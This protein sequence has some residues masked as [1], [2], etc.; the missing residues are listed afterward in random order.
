MYRNN[1]YK[2]R[3]LY[4][5]F[6][7]TLGISSYGQSALLDLKV[8]QLTS[9]GK[10]H[11][12]G[13]IGQ[14][15]T[16][17]WNESGRYILGLEVD[18]IHRMP[19]PEEAAKVFIIDTK[20]DNK[21]IYLDET[22]AWNHQQGTMFYW[23]PKA[24]K[25][26]FFFND[27]DIR[28][29]KVF[30]VLFDIEKKKRIKEYR[31]EDSSV[32][33]G[34]VAWDGSFFMGINYGRLAR[35]RLVTGYPDALDWS[36]E[37]VAP[38]NDGIFKIDIATGKKE[39]LVS[40]RQM[41]NEIIKYDKDFNN[42]GLFINHTLLNRKGDRLY[43]FA[44]E[45]WV[46]GGNKTNVAFSVHLD[47][48][49]LTRHEQHIGGHP[50]WAEG[51]LLIGRQGNKQIFYD[52]DT[53][54]VVKQLG[55][56]EIFPNPEGDIALSPDGNWFVNGYKKGPENF[57]TVYRLSDDQYVKSEGIYK[58][59]FTGDI[60]IDPA[61]RWNRSSDAILVPGI[62]KNR[63]RQMFLIKVVQHVSSFNLLLMGL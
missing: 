46:K 5:I 15:R 25:T 56:P 18:S 3:F 41:E 35:L 21:L 14:C 48:S 9:G 26:Q 61:P 20:K 50:E 39:L 58:G 36:K 43:F 2:N 40:Y 24:A 6:F 52:V 27:R 32:G 10:H 8:E 55:T 4:L 1:K 31:Y 49:K 29:G 63:I 28:T 44:R 51:S 62:D 53:K 16:I 42:T 13:Y 17:P 11:F 60:R 34:G 30:T 12:F 47:G 22:H 45:G 59:D 57:Y 7:V 33:N 23:N 54:K 38:E 19:Y 37:E